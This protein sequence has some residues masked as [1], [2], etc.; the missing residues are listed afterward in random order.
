MAT[1]SQGGMSSPSRPP[2]QRS[3][4]ACGWLASLRGRGPLVVKDD[5]LYLSGDFSLY[6]F[7][8][9]SNHQLLFYL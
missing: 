4:L 2:S 9:T 7:S 1:V 8:Y 3:W 5:D 6:R